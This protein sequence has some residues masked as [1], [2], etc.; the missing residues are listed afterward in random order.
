MLKLINGVIMKKIIF[1][2]LISI[3]SNIQSRGGA[4]GLQL[5]KVTFGLGGSKNGPIIGVG[6]SP[7]NNLPIA[8]PFVPGDCDCGCNC[9]KCNCFYKIIY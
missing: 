4:I 1:L 5:G 6:P 7:D 3:V 9:S 2:I 8:V